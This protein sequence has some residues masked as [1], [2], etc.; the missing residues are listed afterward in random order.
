[1]STYLPV[2]MLIGY[3]CIFVYIKSQQRS[4]VKTKVGITHVYTLRR[5]SVTA[6]NKE[7]A[8]LLQVNF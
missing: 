2:I 3:A 6:N 5:N 8:L 7:N 1:M 4:W